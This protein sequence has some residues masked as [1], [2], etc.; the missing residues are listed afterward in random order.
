ML[1]GRRAEQLDALDLVR[2]ERLEREPGRHALA[3]DEDLRESGP[4]AAQPDLAAASGTPAERDARQPAQ[5]FA[6]R[7]VTEAL[8]FFPADDDLPGNRIAAQIAILGAA[9]LDTLHG[10]ASRWRVFLH[11]HGLGRR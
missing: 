3:V 9:D 2:R 11:R 7:G 8:D 1:R 4:H 5:H 10:A 6:D